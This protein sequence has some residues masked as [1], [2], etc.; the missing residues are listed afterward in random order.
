MESNSL[1]KKL[2]KPFIQETILA[3]LVEIGPVVFK[4]IFFLVHYIIYVTGAHTN[5][6]T[7]TQTF[8]LIQTCEWLYS[9]VA[10]FF[11]PKVT[12]NVLNKKRTVPADL[13]LP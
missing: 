6:D 8:T 11:P 12:K 1:N 9:T 4:K 3:N 10:S 2:M 7:D 5:K 13:G